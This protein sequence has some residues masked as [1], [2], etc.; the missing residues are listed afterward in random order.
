MGINLEEQDLRYFDIEK[1]L[2]KLA[3]S[4]AGNLIQLQEELAEK[5]S[6]MHVKWVV[7]DDDPTGVQ[8]VHD[9]PV[10]TE[11]SVQ[12]LEK[13][14]QESGNLFYILTN[15]RSLTKYETR[16]LHEEL[17]E[18]LCSASKHS[19]VS[20]QVISR[21][22]STLR[23]HFP[24]E[25][26]VIQDVL[27]KELNIE[28]DGVIFAPFFRAGGRY[29][30]HGVH[31][32][33]QGEWLIPAAQT[34]FA[35]DQTFSYRHSVLADYIEEKSQGNI[36]A[37]SVLH[38]DIDYLRTRDIH[39]I[40]TILMQAEQGQLVVV[41]AFSNED[42]QVFSTV[43]YSC[44][45]RGK[46][47]I[48]RT[49]ADFVKAVAAV[50]DYALLTAEN[51]FP[52]YEDTVHAGLV[53]IGSHTAKSTKQ[54]DCLRSLE[55]LN[56][57]AF[58]SDLVLE[59]RL[60]EESK[61]VRACVEAS[62]KEGKTAVV[63]TGRKVLQKEGDSEEDALQRS[64]L[65]SE[66]LVAVVKNLQERPRYIIAKG[67]ITSSDIGTKAL[68]VKRAWVMGQ[69]EPGIPVWK[70]GEESKFPNIPYI[71]FPGNVGD[72]DTLLKIVK[73]LED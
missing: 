50:P 57:I 60:D 2:K 11:W 31:Y 24:L 46:H 63:Y 49:A 30:L 67:G 20:F 8:T 40:E 55:H 7:L 15:S 23:G 9:I 32:V 66:A 53:I 21:S 37:D 19:G 12:S 4:R 43:L 69:I 41:D 6:H 73:R 62:L 72:E 36:S 28:T 64:V 54:L 52:S 44:I 51:L 14:L 33:K 39:A 18:N 5:A 22:D 58:Q 71:I 35:A 1:E 16:L 17:L 42:L 70:C 34:E 61:R 65:I 38:I 29:T 26:N 59:N 10:Y 47:F 48:Y 68:A 45:A 13:A 56:F 25:T 27:H 3:G